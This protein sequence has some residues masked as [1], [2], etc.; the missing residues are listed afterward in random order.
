MVHMERRDAVAERRQNVPEA[1]RVGTARNKARDLAS[2]RDQ[3]VLDDERLDA[4]AE[5]L[6]VN[7]GIV[8]GAV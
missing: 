8:P 2:G 3:L 4:R 1:R 6:A 7:P 5:G